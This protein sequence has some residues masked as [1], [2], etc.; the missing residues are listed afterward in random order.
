[1]YRNWDSSCPIV[2]FGIEGMEE[3]CRFHPEEDST[4]KWEGIPMLSA[5]VI[6]SPKAVDL[7]TI[8]EASKKNF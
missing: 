3:S 7:E 1:M 5:L 4:G 8:A 6:L 2:R